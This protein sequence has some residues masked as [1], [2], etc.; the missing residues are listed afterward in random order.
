MKTERTWG[1]GNGQLGRARRDN[2]EKNMR[3]RLGKIMYADDLMVVAKGRENN[4]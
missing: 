2:E 3:R 1:D 4:H